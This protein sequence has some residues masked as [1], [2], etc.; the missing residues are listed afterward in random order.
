MI[1]RVNA[2]IAAEG[3]M[4]TL[5]VFDNVF[6]REYLKGLDPKHN[7]PHR[8]ERICLVEVLIDGAMMEFGRINK[9]TMKLHLYL[10]ICRFF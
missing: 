4:N 10:F 6:M 3:S 5:S 7:T 8:L 2:I 9:V 1:H